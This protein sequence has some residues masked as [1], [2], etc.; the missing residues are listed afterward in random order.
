[1]PRAI[2]PNALEA[3]KHRKSGEAFNDPH[4]AERAEGAH[5]LLH[6][7]NR[8]IDRDSLSGTDSQG[9][10]PMDEEADAWFDRELAGCSLADERP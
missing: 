6:R 8:R 1:M 4:L 2:S 9:A 3:V 7:R 10:V 5:Q